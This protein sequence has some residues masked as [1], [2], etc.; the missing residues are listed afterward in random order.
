MESYYV[1]VYKPSRKTN[2][3]VR[4][5]IDTKSNQ[6]TIAFIRRH[7]IFEQQTDLKEG[8]IVTDI[9]DV[10]VEY[11][12]QHDIVRFLSM[13]KGILTFRGMRKTKE[14][15]ATEVLETIAKMN[16]LKKNNKENKMPMS[17]KRNLTRDQMTGFGLVSSL[18][19]RRKKK[20]I[21]TDIN[22]NVARTSIL[23]SNIDEEA[24]SSFQE[25]YHE[26]SRHIPRT[27]GK[28]KVMNSL[29]NKIKNVKSSNNNKHDNTVTKMSS[30]NNHYLNSFV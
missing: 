9:M 7:S 10:S 21:I 30:Q 1:S 23:E 20:T 2:L 5:A 15:T 22:N 3:G 28:A 16:N 12:N 17:K 6:V 26:K 24:K 4:F 14:R 27:T 13:N 18:P 11:M 25:I 19:M 8:D 29:T